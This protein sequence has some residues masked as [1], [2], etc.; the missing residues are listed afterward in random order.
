[1]KKKLTRE[2]EEFTR[3]LSN[4]PHNK[5]NERLSQTDTTQENKNISHEEKDKEAFELE[6]FSTGGEGKDKHLEK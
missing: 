6:D 4:G 1:M 3:Q 2:I 5:P